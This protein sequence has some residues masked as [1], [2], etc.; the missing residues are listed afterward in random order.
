MLSVSKFERLTQFYETG[1]KSNIEVDQ[2]HYEVGQIHYEVGQ[3]HYEV[4][5]LL[6]E[7]GQ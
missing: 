1:C 5:P 6:H 4:G 2:I 3:I 7:V